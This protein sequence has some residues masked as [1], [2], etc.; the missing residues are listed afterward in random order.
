MSSVPHDTEERYDPFTHRIREGCSEELMA[1]LGGG[2]GVSC[3]VDQ[4][5]AS[6]QRSMSGHTWGVPRESREGGALGVGVKS[7]DLSRLPGLRSWLLHLLPLWPWT[8][9]LSCLGVCSL[10]RKMG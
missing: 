4:G 9:Y 6:Q 2:E 1:R 5:I 8:S 10:S 7:V 3:E